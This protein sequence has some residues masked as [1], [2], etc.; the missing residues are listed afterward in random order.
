MRVK[1]NNKV[2]IWLLALALAAS[3]AAM[4]W[5]ASARDAALPAEKT[6]SARP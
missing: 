6:L 1:R 4:A 5:W 2:N 3:V